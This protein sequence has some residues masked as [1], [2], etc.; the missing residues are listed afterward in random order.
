MTTTE[1]VVV[2]GGIGLAAVL[3]LQPR[4]SVG[5]GG[6]VAQGDTHLNLKVAGPL[7][8]PPDVFIYGDSRLAP[9]AQAPGLL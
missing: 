3:L 9:V 4:A 2:F 5:F 7:D 8:T 1:K 6:M